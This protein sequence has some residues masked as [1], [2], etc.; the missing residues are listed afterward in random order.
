MVRQRKASKRLTT[1]HRAKIARKAREHRRKSASAPKS[2]RKKETVIPKELPF[3]NAVIAEAMMAQERAKI[4]RPLALVSNEEPSGLSGHSLISATENVS[5]VS[6]SKSV[7]K[8]NAGKNGSKCH[9]DPIETVRETIWGRISA[10]DLQSNYGLMGSIAP[11]T[12]EAF[13]KAL[14]RSTGKMKKGGIPD[15]HAAAR[16]VLADVCAGK[17]CLSK[18]IGMKP[19]TNGV[20]REEANSNGMDDVA[21]MDATTIATSTAVVSTST[22][23]SELSPEFRIA[24]FMSK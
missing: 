15:L 20:R 14:A 4:K 5:S 19:F 13:L 10:D 24:Q 6:I 17:L 21:I 22:I 9:T 8:I 18:A 3:R 23:L 7:Y 12:P 2:R 16:K 1:A 11:D